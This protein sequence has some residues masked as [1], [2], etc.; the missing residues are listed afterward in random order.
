MSCARSATACCSR[1]SRPSSPA[2]RRSRT[3]RSSSTWM[4]PPPRRSRPSPRRRS[5]TALG[6]VTPPTASSSSP[7]AA[8]LSTRAAFGTPSR[9]GRASR[10]SE[11]PTACTSTGLPKTVVVRG[12]R[13]TRLVVVSVAVGS[14]RTCATR[15]LPGDDLSPRNRGITGL[16][17]RRDR[18]MRP[19]K[20]PTKPTTSAM[21]ILTTSASTVGAAK[22]GPTTLPAV[23]VTCPVASVCGEPDSFGCAHFIDDDG[24]VASSAG[25]SGPS[26]CA[27]LCSCA[28][29]MLGALSCPRVCSSLAGLVPCW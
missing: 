22:L 14:S 25:R 23:G 9:A 3:S 6:T 4:P 2:R 20:T 11:W 8:I 10:G 1:A 12:R 28:L 26:C 13:R 21:T 7:A 19:P 18:S 17:P 16:P 24:D 15:S 27:L 29:E 5:S